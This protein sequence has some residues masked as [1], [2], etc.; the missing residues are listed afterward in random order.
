MTNLDPS[1]STY[2]MK[3]SYANELLDSFLKYF[4]YFQIFKKLIDSLPEY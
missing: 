1:T 4:K 2:K 3:K